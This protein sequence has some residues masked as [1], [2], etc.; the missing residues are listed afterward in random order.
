M[1]V[2]AKFLLALGIVIFGVSCKNNEGQQGWGDAPNEGSFPLLTIQKEKT[3]LYT[4]Y[5]TTLK[6]IRDI[7]IRPKI[8][9][10]IESILV[11]EGQ[12]V[13]KGQPLFVLYAP[14]YQDE[15]AAA[16]AKIKEAQAEINKAQLHIDKTRPLV[17][18][19][20]ISPYE[21]ETAVLT[22]RSKEA[23][24]AQL[25]AEQKKSSVNVGYTK[26]TAPFDGYVG[27]IPYKVGALVQAFS[28]NPLT[29]LSDITSVSAYFSMSEKQFLLLAQKA[30]KQ[31][32]LTYL[33]SLAAVELQLSDQQTYPEKGIISALS[34]QIDPTTGSINV[35]AEF[36][37]PQHLLRSGTSGVIRIW[38]EVE[39]AIVIPQ[40]A[41]FDIQGKRFVYVVNKDKV[42]ESREIKCLPQE[43]SETSYIVSEGLAEGE[44]LVKEE[45]GGAREGMRVTN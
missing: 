8:E 5:P 2:C 40:A 6:G 34:G 12:W 36:A 37:N 35:R 7:E 32:I 26:I 10:Y 13:K 3:K 38:E 20:I 24:L 25:R 27:L 23:Y 15:D 17:N 31:S 43:P 19:G 18:E 14:H 42:L 16:Q 44:L 11:D 41:T 45:I 1:N 33:Q 39:E 4:T 9:G 30:G 22:L 21:L 28:S 29:T